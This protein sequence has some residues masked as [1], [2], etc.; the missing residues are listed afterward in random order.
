MLRKK[1]YN[2]DR[3]KVILKMN[4][5]QQNSTTDKTDSGCCQAEKN[6]GAAAANDQ[7]DE[8]NDAK[9]IESNLDKKLGFSSDYDVIK[10]RPCEKRKVDFRN[11]LV[12]SPLTTVGNLPFR[13]ICKEFGAVSCCCMLLGK[14]LMQ[15]LLEKE[16][17]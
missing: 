11:K 10:E 8:T 1:S 6:G 17:Y 16:M 7:N 9:V 3:S 4:N 13:R 5:K 12:L 14:F 15:M 2:Y